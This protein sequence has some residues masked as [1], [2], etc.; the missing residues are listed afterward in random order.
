M[1][2]KLEW[3][4]ARLSVFL[5]IRSSSTSRW[6]IKSKH[7][8]IS[9]YIKLPPVG[10]RW[11]EGLFWLDTRALY[12]DRATNYWEPI[13]ENEGQ[14]YFYQENPDWERIYKEFARVL[15]DRIIK[16]NKTEKRLRSN[17]NQIETPKSKQTNQ[18][19]SISR[20]PGSAA[21]LAPPSVPPQS[22]L[23]GLPL[24]PPPGLQ[25]NSQVYV[26]EISI[27]CYDIKSYTLFCLLNLLT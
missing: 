22:S 5:N 12:F 18:G 21:P 23:S 20:N 1:T 13:P 4:I 3:W 15:P 25:Q 7:N 24:V 27:N 10:T 16:A 9:K 17:S 2:S 26:K 6:L 14:E 8:K 19:N 11:E